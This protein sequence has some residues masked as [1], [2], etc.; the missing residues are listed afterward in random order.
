MANCFRRLSEP[1]F[2]GFKDCE[3]IWKVQSAICNPKSAIC[4]LK[5]LHDLL[6]IAPA[7][8]WQFVLQPGWRLFYCI[9]FLR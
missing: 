4:N 2:G 7:A 1:G 8:Q 3:E 5:W 9:L 6:T